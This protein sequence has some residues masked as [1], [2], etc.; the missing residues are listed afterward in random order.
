MAAS[1]NDFDYTSL[2]DRD[3]GSAFVH[4]VKTVKYFTTFMKKFLN[5]WLKYD[6]VYTILEI[7]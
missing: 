3:C 7:S 4:V 2:G 5:M 6:I 1:I